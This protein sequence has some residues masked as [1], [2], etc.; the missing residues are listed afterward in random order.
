MI[1]P[2]AHRKILKK[3][4]PGRARITAFAM[5]ER[6][7]SSQNIPMTLEVHVEGLSPYE[8]EDQW[9]VSSKD[10]LGFGLEVPVKVDPDK[11]EKVAIDWGAAREERK[12][13]KAAREASLASQPAVGGSVAIQDPMAAAGLAGALGGLGGQAAGGATPVVDARND[14]QLRAKLEQLL[15]RPLEP[16][17]EQTI[18]VSTDPA[19]AARIMAVVQQHQAEI[20]AGAAAGAQSGAASGGGDDALSKLERLAKLRD[21]GA[22]TDSEFDQEKRQLLDEL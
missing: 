4:K 1:N 21:S 17:T 18:D 7:A 8:V 2:F 14:P 12:G 3:G 6:G 5:P 22:L 13:E 15:G 11:P 9:M 10:T 16:G 19:M 20:A